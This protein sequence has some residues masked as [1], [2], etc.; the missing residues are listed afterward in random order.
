MSVCFCDI[1]TEQLGA[2]LSGPHIAHKA[3][4]RCPNC[5]EPV[6]PGELCM[7]HAGIHGDCLSGFFGR[8]HVLCFQ[9]MERFAWELCGDEYSWHWPFDI[10]EASGHA[11]AHGDEPFWKDWLLIYGMR[12][13]EMDS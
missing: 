8:F 11:M 4:R 2:R 6:C 5:G 13:E 9:L 10:H 1:E 3:G 12:L 7:D